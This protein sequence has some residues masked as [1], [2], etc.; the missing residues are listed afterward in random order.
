MAEIRIE[1]PYDVQRCSPNKSLHWA[2]RN[3]RREAAWLLARKAWADAGSP[4]SAGPVRVSLLIQR[5][6]RLDED[7]A[8]ACCKP[9]IDALFKGAITPDDN[10]QW[11]R[12]GTLMQATSGIYH[13]NESVIVIAEPIEPDAAPEETTCP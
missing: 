9:I 1:V 3:R 11:V 12:F 8:I 13:R 5:A 2:E 10:P 4:V 7:N 6:R